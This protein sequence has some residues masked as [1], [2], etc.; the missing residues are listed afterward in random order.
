[1]IT[2]EKQKVLDLFAEGR[3]LYKLM[4]FSE[5]KAKFIEALTFDQNDGPSKKYLERCEHYEGDPPPEDWDGVFVMKT[6]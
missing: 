6:K 3:K 1:M 4:K 2:P 5:A